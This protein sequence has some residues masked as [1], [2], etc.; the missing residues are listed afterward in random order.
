MQKRKDDGWQRIVILLV[1]GGILLAFF[2]FRAP[3]TGK[4]ILEL[5][6][7]VEGKNLTGLLRMHM[8][9]GELIP[10]STKVIATLEGQKKEYRLYDL[11]KDKKKRGDFF[12]EETDINGR[13]DGYGFPGKKIVYPKVTVHLIIEKEIVQEQAVVHDGDGDTYSPP[14]DCDDSAALIHP[15][16]TEKCNGI[17]DNCANGIDEGCSCRD[18]A[19]QPC[20]TDVG[21]CSLGEQTCNN[22]AWGDCM[23]DVGPLSPE[24]CNQKDDNC[25]GSV[26]ENDV[27]APEG[28][29]GLPPPP[30]DPP[31]PP[32]T[33]QS[34]SP[35]LSPS[36]SPTPGPSPSS[37]TGSVINFFDSLKKVTGY[38]TGYFTGNII[39]DYTPS[40]LTGRAVTIDER[41]V[42]TDVSASFNYSTELKEGETI[43]VVSASTAS[44][45]IALDQI[46]IEQMG[47]TMIVFT[48][49]SEEEIGFGQEYLLDQLHPIDITLSELKLRP[50]DGILKVALFYRGEEI[51]DIARDIK[52]EEEREALCALEDFRCRPSCLPSEERKNFSCASGVCC[53]EEELQTC[54]ELHGDICNDTEWCSTNEVDASDG[55]CCLGECE[56]IESDEIESD[57]GDEVG[58]FGE[59]CEDAGF[60]C[61][62]SC[63]PSE[64]RKNFSC[65]FGVCC[66]LKNEVQTC[67]ELG[68]EVCDSYSACTEEETDAEEGGCCLAECKNIDDQDDGGEQLQSDGGLDTESRGDEES[69]V[70]SNDEILEEVQQSDIPGVRIDAVTSRNFV[71]GAIARFIIL[72]DNRRSTLLEDVY[73]NLVLNDKEQTTFRSPQKDIL[74][75]SKSEIIAYGDTSSLHEGTYSGKIIFVYQDENFEKGVQVTISKDEAVVILEGRT[76]KKYLFFI[77]SAII[78][79]AAAL[80]FFSLKFLKKRRVYLFSFSGFKSRLVKKRGRDR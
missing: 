29:D 42:Q 19:I 30:D 55:A 71:L 17:N 64:E 33:L 35:H 2:F 74:P 52:V 26:D 1:L 50:V 23:G 43:R 80:G 45:E 47:N 3:Q 41:S 32:E 59:L 34:P 18:G 21:A 9:E 57:E 66:G 12:V 72:I 13:G 11:V 48:T 7:E 60:L 44:G 38:I 39:R 4:V 15:D 25:D 67:D 28:D 5:K 46:K 51:L 10:A 61:E 79:L 70:E 24:T 14:G 16:A 75:N 31:S 54:S 69:N 36:E 62:S 40:P 73:V 78:A 76:S 68:G 37:L 58:K 77:L 56:E 53:G 6:P 27:C 8:K 20:G 63:L 22:G 49:Y 65:A